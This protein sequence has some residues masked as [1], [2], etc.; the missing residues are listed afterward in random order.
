MIQKHI[1]TYEIKVKNIDTR[2]QT[3]R[4]SVLK[5]AIYNKLHNND[6]A[7]ALNTNKKNDHDN[8]NNNNTDIN[9]NNNNI[10]NKYLKCVKD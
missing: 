10:N 4:A 3:A 7:I 6:K 8:N 1:H 5:H 9:N 2:P